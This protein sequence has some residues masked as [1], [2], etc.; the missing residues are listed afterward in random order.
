MLKLI[1]ELLSWGPPYW[2]KD[3]AQFESQVS[4]KG[5]KAI[6]KECSIA[7][8][9]SWGTGKRYILKKRMIKTDSVEAEVSWLLIPSMDQAPTTLDPSLPIMQPTATLV[10]DPSFILP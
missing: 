8:L 9:W 1:Q 7:L 4:D 3:I 6:L 5:V 10:L 2:S